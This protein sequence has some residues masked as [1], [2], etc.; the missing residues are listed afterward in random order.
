MAISSTTHRAILLALALALTAAA[1]ALTSG[2]AF[3]R[4]NTTVNAD[5]DNCSIDRNGLKVPGTKSGTKC[6]NV[7]DTADCVELSKATITNMTQVRGS[8]RKTP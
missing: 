2:P 5:G 3:A 4:F 8:I 1:P 7:F 6:C